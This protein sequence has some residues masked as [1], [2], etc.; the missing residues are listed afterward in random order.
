MI[1]SHYQ[2]QH[3]DDLPNEC[4][5]FCNGKGPS[6]LL[7][8]CFDY[9]LKNLQT[10][11]EDESSTDKLKLRDNLQLPV[12]ICE[13]LLCNWW[14]KGPKLTAH[15]LNIFRNRQATRLKRVKLSNCDIDDKSLK[16]LLQHKLLTLDISHCSQL[17]YKCL[18]YLS[19]YGGTLLALSMDENKDMFPVNKF[20]SS[21]NLINDEFYDKK[22]IFRAPKLKKL[23]VKHLQG[24]RPGFYA[25]LLNQM[26]NLTHLDLSNC[27]DLGRMYYV[28]RLTNLT[29]LVLFNVP[30]LENAI[31][32]I[33]KLKSLQHL[34]VAQTKDDDGRYEQ[35]TRALAMIVEGL[36][37]LTSLDISGTNLPSRGVAEYIEDKSITYTS[38]IPGLSSRSGNP[39]HFLGL[40][41]TQHD[42]CF[43]HDIP[44]KLV[45]L[46]I[47]VGLVKL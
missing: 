26:T 44:A 43:R 14:T 46:N 11:C 19:E 33:S 42:A 45:S 1:E 9:I 15:F 16:I 38:D 32:S 23:S 37:K 4:C 30:K 39:F 40:Y 21:L 29:S 6:R 2:C 35:P 27:T 8:I 5:T 25:I 34:D 36:P 28:D 18:K 24:L 13:Q 17:T 20:G 47:C 10:I 12:E 3:C 31:L 41:D 22:Y 7:D